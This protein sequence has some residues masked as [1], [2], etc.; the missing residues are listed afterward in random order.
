[1]MMLAIA[2]EIHYE[3][4]MMYVGQVS[5]NDT[6]FAVY[7][8]TRATSNRSKAHMGAAIHVLRYLAG[9]INVSTINKQGGF[10]LAAYSD[11]NWGNNPDCEK[12]TSLYIVM[13]VNGFISFRPPKSNRAINNGSGVCGSSAHH[14][15]GSVLLQ[16]DG[17][18]RLLERGQWHAVVA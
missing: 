1:M 17:G 14:E 15:G 3:I 13:L 8:L 6:R 2:V 18:A 16:L 12:S 4:Y 5:R 10:K 9:S 11:A 7:K